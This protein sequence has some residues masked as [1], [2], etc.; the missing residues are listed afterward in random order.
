[1]DYIDKSIIKQLSEGFYSA[2]HAYPTLCVRSSGRMEL[3]GNHTDHQGGKVLVA[4][5]NLFMYAA[6]KSR[7]DLLVNVH[8]KGFPSFSIDLNTLTKQRNEMFTSAA[9]IRGI[10]SKLNTEGY[11]IGGFDLYIESDVPPGSGV[12]SSAAFEMLIV[13]VLNQTLNQGKILPILRAKI[14]QFA[15]NEYF[16][17]PSG[18][19]DQMGVSLGGVNFIDFQDLD[20][21]RYET[22]QFPFSSLRFALID[23]GGSHA[24][25]TQHYQAIRTDMEQVAIKMGGKKLSEVLYADFVKQSLTLTLPRRTLNRAK[26]Y[27]EE[28]HR[29]EAAVKDL[30]TNNQLGFMLALNQSGISSETLLENIT[31]NED[32]DQRLAKALFS[33]RHAN[34]PIAVRVH[35]GGFAGTIL[36]AYDVRDEKTV[37]ANVETLFLKKDIIFVQ[38]VQQPLTSEVIH[39]TK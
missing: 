31:F 21:L 33:L 12:S 6:V 10:A 16:G 35:G 32:I 1:M 5:I 11:T 18:L 37:M 23:T 3:L 13:E 7:Q 4:A 27:F 28:N 15:E 34:L 38:P 8:S 2:F 36:L 29:V 9:I 30:K 19:L 26:H 17:K 14:G 20:H 39:G 24:N 22:F 25:L